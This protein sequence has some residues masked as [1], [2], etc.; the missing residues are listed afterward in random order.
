[1]RYW[2]SSG[3]PGTD[4]AFDIG[5]MKIG[6][7]LAIKILNASKFALTMGAAVDTAAVV[8]PLDIRLLARLSNVVTS[9]TAAFEDYNYPG[10]WRSP[11]PSSGP[12]ATTTWNWSKTGTYGSRSEAGAASAKATL[13]LALSVQLRLFAPSYPS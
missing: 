5:Q 11:R 8:D 13:A 9:A 1:M 10:R 7:R 6:G 2:A 3:R 12:S 4:T